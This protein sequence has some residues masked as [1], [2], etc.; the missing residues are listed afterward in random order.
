LL[1][2]GQNWNTGKRVKAALYSTQAYTSKLKSKKFFAFEM[3]Q[4]QKAHSDEA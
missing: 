3:M 2:Q 1:P 4:Q